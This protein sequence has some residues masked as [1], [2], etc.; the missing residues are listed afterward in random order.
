MSGTGGRVL[1]IQQRFM[2]DVLLCTPAIRALRRARPHAT[3]DF[4]AEPAGADALRGNPHLDA[5]VAW[6]RQRNALSIGLELR[7]RRYD[8]VVDFR[9]TP[10]TAQAAWLTGAR[11]RIGFRGRGPRNLLYTRL[12][13][14]DRGPTYMARKKLALLR[15]LGIDPDGVRDVDLEIAIGDAEREAAARV[16]ERLA[17]GPDG[18]LVAVS[19][20]ARD[21]CKQWGAERWAAVADRLVAAGA[22]VV[23]TCGP[24]EEPQVREV[25]EAMRERVALQF[26]PGNVRELAAL[27]QRCA[28]WVGNDGGGRHVAVAAGVSTVGVIRREATVWTDT[29][30]GSRHTYVTGAGAG[31]GCRGTLDSLPVQ[32]V[33]QVVLDTLRPSSTRQC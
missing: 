32:R 27:L 5:I 29:S 21:P 26:E 15:P 6:P 17:P 7:R 8:V 4:L 12:E 1:L 24:G 13:E 2:G 30:P 19:A 10:S 23:L 3:L 9:S 25:R 33:L 18:P 16:L 31:E 20:V 28:L 22:R 14:H 11:T